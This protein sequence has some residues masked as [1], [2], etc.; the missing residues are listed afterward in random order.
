MERTCQ[1]LDPGPLEES[2]RGVSA[3]VVELVVG[4]LSCPVRVVL[5]LSILLLQ[6]VPLG[7]H[8]DVGR[9]SSICLLA[10]THTIMLLF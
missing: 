5:D 3:V 7:T 10:V 1:G 8:C 2:G 4:I 6:D 9:H